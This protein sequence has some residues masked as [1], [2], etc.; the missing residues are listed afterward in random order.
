MLAA[1]AKSIVVKDGVFNWDKEQPNGPTLKD[2][3]LQVEPGQL[4]AVVG[5]VG[6]GKSSLL[7]AMLGEMETISGS[8]ILNVSPF[9]PHFPLLLDVFTELNISN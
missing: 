9:S 1:V 6:T 5:Q 4:V 8:V 3:E 2:M 7:S